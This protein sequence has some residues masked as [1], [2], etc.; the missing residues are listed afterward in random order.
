MAHNQPDNKAEVVPIG[1]SGYA[2]LFTDDEII[3]FKDLMRIMRHEICDRRQLL[4]Q[5]G[6]L[7]EVGDVK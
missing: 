2:A 7:Q 1:F 4:I 5:I 6:R 3:Y